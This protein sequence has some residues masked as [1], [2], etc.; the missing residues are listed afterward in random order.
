MRRL[1]LGAVLSLAALG[2]A[3]IASAGTDGDRE[4]VVVYQKGADLGAAREAV[5]AAGGK[6]VSE[7][8]AIGVARCGV[9]VPVPTET[10]RSHRPAVGPLV[11]SEPQ[12]SSPTS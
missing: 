1:M 2:A 7:N 6:I 4:Y 9:A 8:A 3:G 11:A 5:E 12:P 10:R